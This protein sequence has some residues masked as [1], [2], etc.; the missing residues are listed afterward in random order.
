LEVDRVRVCVIGVVE[1]QRIEG[2]GAGL[3]LLV[4]GSVDI[5]D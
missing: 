4:D 2:R 1:K 5:V 3:V